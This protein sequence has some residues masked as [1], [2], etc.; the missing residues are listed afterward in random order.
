M[1]VCFGAGFKINMMS[2]FNNC[3]R[4]IDN[5]VTSHCVCFYITEYSTTVRA[6]LFVEACNYIVMTL[7]GYN[8]TTFYKYSAS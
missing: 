6:L 5:R 4:I 3:D 2:T 1:S 7:S 8:C